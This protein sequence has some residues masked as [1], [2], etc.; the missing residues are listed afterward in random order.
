M[1]T[2][3]GRTRGG[4][5]GYRIFVFLLKHLGLSFAYFTLRFVAFYFLIFSK[6]KYIYFFFRKILHY[7][8]LKSI[9]SIYRNY[10]VFGQT[11]LDKTALLA[12]FDS[13]FTFDFEGE[14]FLREMKS[15]GIIISAHVGNWEIAGQ[16]L[17]RLNTKINLLMFDAEHE[18][19]KQYLDQILVH[20]N[21]SIIII[22]EDLSHLYEI[23]N[24]L[25][26]NELIAMHGD[27]FLE[28][29]KIITCCFL[30]K[31]ASFPYGPFYLASKFN[32]PVSFTYAMKESKY[33]YHF[34]ATPLY[35]LPSV[36]SKPEREK[37]ITDL[38]N[39]Y[40]RETE[41][42]LK[43]YPVQWFNYYDFWQIDA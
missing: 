35:I 34:Y 33:H 10:Y 27:R 4:V 9:V 24:A 29:S 21:V 1:V 36:V 12:G 40:A 20:R 25:A 13:K 14:R 39:K 16:L 6:K 42:M 23:K 32:V 17:K 7:S 15:G 3:Q 2:W 18:R 38:V 22:K 19:I 41:K 26:R 31:E 11:L 30:G 8:V 37:T 43:K 5:L 28:K